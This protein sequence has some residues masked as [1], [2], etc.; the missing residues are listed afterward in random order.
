[1]LLLSA[2]VII[3]GSIQFGLLAAQDPEFFV[4]SNC[5]GVCGY[6]EYVNISDYSDTFSRHGVAFGD[7]NFPFKSIYKAGQFGKAWMENSIE[8]LNFLGM[9]VNKNQFIDPVCNIVH[10][11]DFFRPG[12]EQV[13]FTPSRDNGREFL[14][15]RD[16]YLKEPSGISGFCELFPR[17]GILHRK[18]NGDIFIDWIHSYT[19]SSGHPLSTEYSIFILMN[20]ESGRIR[21]IRVPRNSNDSC[22]GESCNLFEVMWLRSSTFNTS[23][24]LKIEKVKNEVRDMTELYSMF[25]RWKMEEIP[26]MTELLDKLAEGVKKIE[27]LESDLSPSNFAILC[28]PLVMGVVPISLFESVTDKAIAWYVFTTDFLAALPLLIKGVELIVMFRASR[29][30]MRSTISILGERYGIFETWD[31]YCTPPHHI[32]QDVG[33]ILVIVMV[34]FILSMAYVELLYWRKMRISQGR[35][36]TIQD[37]LNVETT[38]DNPQIDGNPRETRKKC[39][40]GRRMSL[41]ILWILFIGSI[42]CQVFAEAS[43]MPQFYLPANFLVVVLLVLLRAVTTRRLYQFGQAQF[44]VGILIGFFGGPLYLILHLRLDVRQSTD[45]GEKCEGANLGFASLVAVLS[46]TL[47]E[48]LR[49]KLMRFPESTLFVFTLFISRITLHTIRSTEEDKVLWRYGVHGFALGFLFGPFGLLFRH[50]FPELQG[51]VK[52]TRFNFFTGFSYVFELILFVFIALSVLSF[53]I[54]V[55]G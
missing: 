7:E 50:C 34:W 51:V 12:E 41:T 16:L 19:F 37:L 9:N 27:N 6:S 30:K 2:L 55:Y 1:M 32:L 25:T 18:A 28:L 21:S 8:F 40:S 29:P 23:V 39:M 10:N 24:P 38:I 26:G 33:T 36:Q 52:K 48:T 31:V 4:P 44:L 3:A 45:W 42:V 49:S 5:N 22:S 14:E 43:I 54:P 20:E 47:T 15:R 13:V 11:P 53:N 17:R 46:T 35:L